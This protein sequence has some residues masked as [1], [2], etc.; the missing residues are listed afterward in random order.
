M[1]WAY[2]AL[3]AE[4]AEA[5]GLLVPTMLAEGR[6][7]VAWAQE[8]RR[9]GARWDSTSPYARYASLQLYSDA[10][11]AAGGRAYE[12]A[13]A[14]GRWDMAYTDGELRFVGEGA[15]RVEGGVA[16]WEAAASSD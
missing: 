8:Q 16:R 6:D 15:W 5:V 13:L 1:S 9:S 7:A 14:D 3:G 11:L 4:Q 12:Q 10:Q 2:Q